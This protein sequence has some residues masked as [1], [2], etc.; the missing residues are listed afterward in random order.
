[1]KEK[2]VAALPANTFENSLYEKYKPQIYSSGALRDIERTIRC[3]GPRIDRE[4]SA[5]MQTIRPD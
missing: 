2:K 1:L 3:S 5:A 4:A